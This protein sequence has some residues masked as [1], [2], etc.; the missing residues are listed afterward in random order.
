ML[1]LLAAR[2]TVDGGTSAP[3]RLGRGRTLRGV[4][5]VADVPR[6]EEGLAASGNGGGGI[7]DST[8]VDWTN[9][10][11]FSGQAKYCTL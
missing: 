11:Q 9:I 2:V 8:F 4:G 10:P 1:L 3:P 6:D 7:E 5:P